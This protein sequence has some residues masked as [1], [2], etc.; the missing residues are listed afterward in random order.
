MVL[1]LMLPHP[2]KVEVDH[3]GDHV[4]PSN[5]VPGHRLRYNLHGSQ[6]QDRYLPLLHWAVRVAACHRL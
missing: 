6:D 3:G 2:V 4:F 1:A 5:A